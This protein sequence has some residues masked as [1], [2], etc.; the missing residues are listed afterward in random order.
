M[1]TMWEQIQEEMRADLI[2]AKGEEY[3]AALRRTLEAQARRHL[4]EHG[5]NKLPLVREPAA[6]APE[7]LLELVQNSRRAPVDGYLFRAHTVQEASPGEILVQDGGRSASQIREAARPY[8]KVIALASDDD[9]LVLNPAKLLQDIFI[10]QIKVGLGIAQGLHQ[11]A[12]I[13]L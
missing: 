13:V 11:L 5:P 9:L 6:P 4:L 8:D 3:V 1:I 12:N 10:A 7:A 2:A